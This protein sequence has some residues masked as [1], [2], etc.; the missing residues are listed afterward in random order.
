MGRLNRRPI[1]YLYLKLR[2]G[3]RGIVV[4]LAMQELPMVVAHE[5]FDLRHKPNDIVLSHLFDDIE[6]LGIQIRNH[7]DYDHAIVIVFHRPGD[8]PIHGEIRVDRI[9]RIFDVSAKIDGAVVLPAS[10]EWELVLE[11]LQK[12]VTPDNYHNY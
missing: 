10:G 5:I 4:R 11:Y 7:V 2:A 8:H 3:E 9:R 1:V 12:L 6:N